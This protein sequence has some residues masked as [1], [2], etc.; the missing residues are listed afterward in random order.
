MAEISKRIEYL[1]ILATTPATTEESNV[2]A[3]GANQPQW[4]V[5]G[6]SA[7]GHTIERWVVVL[8][9]KICWFLEHRPLEGAVDNTSETWL[10]Y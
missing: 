4:V 7:A 1:T 10:G 3:G 6:K 8:L 9:T 2:A 5:P